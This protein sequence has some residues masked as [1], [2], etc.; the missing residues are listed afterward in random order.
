M[1][2]DPS[3]YA[4]HQ[5]VFANR[6]AGGEDNFEKTYPYIVQRIA[7]VALLV[8]SELCEPRPHE[9][10]LLLNLKMMCDLVDRIPLR[11]ID[12]ALR[13]INASLSDRETRVVRSENEIWLARR[14]ARSG[15]MQYTAGL[16]RLGHG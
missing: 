16:K 1:I 6:I 7:T 13:E 2:A 10:S 15:S 3:I 9:G 5:S 12:C 11:W 14:D 4:A 8:D